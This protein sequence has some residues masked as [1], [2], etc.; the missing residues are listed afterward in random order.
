[1]DGALVTVL[2]DRTPAMSTYLLAWVLGE[3]ESV[4]SRTKRDVLV[5]VWTTLGKKGEAELACDVA[6]RCLDWCPSGMRPNMSVIDIT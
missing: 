4:E 5:R 6:C 2:F 3:F 1:M